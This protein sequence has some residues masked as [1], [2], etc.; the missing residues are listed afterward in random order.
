MDPGAPIQ[1]PAN[2]GGVG[3]RRLVAQLGVMQRGEVVDRNDRIRAPGRRYDEVGAVDHVD[4]SHKPFDGR[5]VGAGPQRVERTRRHGA[6]ARG[7]AGRQERV[8][9]VAAAPADG[10]GTDGQPRPCSQRAERALAEDPDAGCLAEQRRRVDRHP[11]AHGGG[12]L[13][14]RRRGQV[15]IAPS[16]ERIAPVT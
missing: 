10:I 12:A 11:Q 6:L 9:A 14:L 4:R 5:K 1:G 15:V 13:D 16:M 2:Q 8:D 3:Q 7:H